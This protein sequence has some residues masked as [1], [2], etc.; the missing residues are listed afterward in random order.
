MSGRQEALKFIDLF[1][2]LA[3]IDNF[4]YLQFAKACGARVIATTS[5]SAKS[6]A[7]LKLGA[8]DVL[9]YHTTPSWGSA[10]KA[11]TPH[12]SGVKHVLEVGGPATMV[13]ALAAIAPEGVISIIGYLSG[14]G[15]DDEASFLDCLERDC[16]VRRIL[17]GSRMLFE[18]VVEAVEAGAIKP[19]IDEREWG[20]QEAPEAMQWMADNKN[21]VSTARP[22]KRPL[23]FPCRCSFLESFFAI[24]AALFSLGFSTLIM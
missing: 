7:L 21:F 2:R 5:S 16:T 10:A 17:V 15:R 4:S 20:I 19:V 22:E 12:N 18:Q 13:Q 14:T 11:L 23:R 9:N 1:F 24:V 8:N 3:I 6:D